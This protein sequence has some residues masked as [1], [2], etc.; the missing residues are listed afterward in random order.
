MSREE[1][2]SLLARLG[3]LVTSLEYAAPEAYAMWIRRIRDELEEARDE[4]LLT[5]R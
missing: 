2:E 3:A 1:I 5:P 4:L